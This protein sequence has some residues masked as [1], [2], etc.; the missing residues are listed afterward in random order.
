MANAKAKARIGLEVL[1]TVV[2]EGGLPHLGKTTNVSTSGMLL[3]IARP[4]DVGVR[5]QLK[6]FLPGVGKKLDVAGEVTRDAGR[7]D[8]VYRYGVQFV[9]MP[10]ESV[11]EIE[12]FLAVRLD[13]HGP[14]R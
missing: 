3:E 11:A 12:R 13:R 8:D 14:S 4:L 2:P 6:L 9:E 7:T 5:V 1:V 10:V